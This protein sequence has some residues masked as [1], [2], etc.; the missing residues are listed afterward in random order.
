MDRYTTREFAVLK[1]QLLLAPRQV[2]VRLLERIEELLLEISAGKTYPFDYLVYRITDH[3]PESITPLVL[4]A[5][6]TSQALADILYEVGR[7]VAVAADSLPEPVR[8]VED[9]ASRWRVSPATILRWRREGL[10]LRLF[11]FDGARRK[12]GVRESLAAH[13]ETVR[14]RLIRRAITR[15]RLSDTDRNAILEQA[16][17]GLAR[18]ESPGRLVAALS[19]GFALTQS[20][21]ERLLLAA[22]RNNPALRAFSRESIS[23]RESEIILAESSNGAAAG[24]IA[25]RLGLPVEKVDRLILRARARKLLRRPLKLVPNP[26]F[27]FPDAART[28]LDVPRPAAAGAG[29][30]ASAD[31]LPVYLKGIAGVALLSKDEERS[32]FRKYNYLKYLASQLLRS[33]DIRRLDRSLVERIESLLADATRVRDRIITSNL[34]LVPSIAKRHST[35]MVAFAAIV[36]EGNMALIDAVESFDYARGNR[37]STYAGWAIT[38]RFARMLPQEASRVPTVDDEILDAAARVETDFD[39]LKPAVVAA[40]VTRALASLPGRDRFV[41]ESRFG[42]GDRAKPATL[43]ELGALFGV[44]K[45]R[46]RQIELQALRRLRRIVEKTAPDLVPA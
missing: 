42:L 7:S 31:E 5:E 29:P 12:A 18:E 35:Q 15:R 46:V 13:F 10:P 41:I 26:E 43:A 38:R 17:V 14:A 32:L 4:I 37:F 34:R 40:G 22:A 25:A 30:T 21:V 23:R 27:D 36:S 3:R 19:D 1:H 39:A 24:R 9:L 8:T 33:L 6:E 2:K 28:I 11:R 45:E 20:A 16:L 44:T